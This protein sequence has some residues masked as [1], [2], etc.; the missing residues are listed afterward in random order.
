MK[1]IKYRNYSIIKELKKNKLIDD[2]F[3]LICD[4]LKL[5]D[6]I[7][8][9]IELFS[10]HLNYKLFGFPLWKSV[11]DM[12]RDALL[13]VSFKIAASKTEASRMLGVDL[14]DY[15]KYLKQFGYELERNTK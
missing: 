5:E 6:I 1:R 10:R 13:K 4:S 14:S 9:K 2:Q 11:P 3:I 12:V 8:I 7:G 15:K